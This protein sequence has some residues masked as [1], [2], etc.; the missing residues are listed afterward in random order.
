[1]KR[2]NAFLSVTISIIVLASALF[3]PNM[4]FAAGA[5]GTVITL[6]KDDFELVSGYNCSVDGNVVTSTA[7]QY[8]SFY[9]LLGKEYYIREIR[10]T[11]TAEGRNYSTSNNAISL[12]NGAATV[13]SLPWSYSVWTNGV[14]SVKTASVPEDKQQE[15]VNR[16]NFAGF[17]TAVPTVGG[18]SLT[19]EK[20]EIIE[21]DIL[22][23]QE[24]KIKNITSSEIGLTV[25]INEGD[26]IELRYSKSLIDKNNFEDAAEVG[27]SVNGTYN[28]SGLE[29]DTL[30]YLALRVCNDSKTGYFYTSATTL[31]ASQ[32][33]SVILNPDDFVVEP[34]S[35]AGVSG[36]TVQAATG[37]ESSFMLCLPTYY[38][39]EGVKITAEVNDNSFYT[40]DAGLQLFDGDTNIANLGYRTGFGKDSAQTRYFSVPENQRQTPVNTI[41]IFGKWYDFPT[42]D[43]DS[44]ITI[45]EIE[46][47]GSEALIAPEMEFINITG[48]TVDVNWEPID[49]AEFELWYSLEPLTSVNF[50]DVTEKNLAASGAVTSAVISGLTARAEYYFLLK[51]ALDGREAFSVGKVVPQPLDDDWIVLGEDDFKLISSYNCTVNGNVVTSTANQYPAFYISFNNGYHIQEIRITA[52]SEGRNYSTGDKAVSLRNDSETVYSLPWSWSVWSDGVQSVKTASVPEDKQQEIVNRINFGGFWRAAPSAGG[53][54]F[55]VNK[56]EIKGSRIIDEPSIV[57]DKVTDA[58]VT[59]NWELPDNIGVR[60]WISENEL[61][62]DNFETAEKTLV[63]SGRMRSAKVDG[64]KQGGLYYFALEVLNGTEKLLAFSS[65]KLDAAVYDFEKSTNVDDYKVKTRSDSDRFYFI[66]ASEGISASIEKTEEYSDYGNAFKMQFAEYDKTRW[67]ILYFY[68]PN[69]GDFAGDGFSVTV[70]KTKN[71]LGTDIPIALNVQLSVDGYGVYQTQEYWESETFSADTKR[72]TVEFYYEDFFL[73][74][75]SSQKMTKEL[76]EHITAIRFWFEIPTSKGAFSL[77]FDSVRVIN[78]FKVVREVEGLSFQN[79]VVTLSEG[80]STVQTPVFE[81][82]NAT[83]NDLTWSTDAP[84]VISVDEVSGNAVA[85]SLGIAT[86]YATAPSG[87]TASYK[88]VV[89]EDERGAVYRDLFSFDDGV[90]PDNISLGNAS[91]RLEYSRVDTGGSLYL[92]SEENISVVFTVNDY[93]FY[94]EGIGIWACGD[95]GGRYVS[96]DLITDDNEVFTYSLMIDREIGNYVTLSYTEF[97]SRNSGKSPDRDDII[98]FKKLRISYDGSLYVDS[99]KVKDPL[100]YNL[101]QF[102]ANFTGNTGAVITDNNNALG[103]F[104]YYFNLLENGTDYDWASSILSESDLISY[105]SD[106]LIYSL[107]FVDDGFV[108]QDLKKSVSV[109]LDIPQIFEGMNNIWILYLTEGK[110]QGVSA[111]I[112]GSKISFEAS[113]SGIYCMVAGSND[114]FLSRRIKSAEEVEVVID[115]G[116]EPQI[117]TRDITTI[118]RKKDSGSSASAPQH[119]NPVIFWIVIPIAVLVI[120]GGTVTGILLF[121]KHRNRGAG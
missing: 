76:S 20:I 51:A 112:V 2:L 120:A 93:E 33:N 53:A 74:S 67:P 27:P 116:T 28:I 101:R 88:I 54:Q 15:G 4:D 96:L 109:T 26:N 46:L 8:P 118:R 87:V 105:A 113:K 119:I 81:P 66:N 57:F 21:S 114:E 82:Y 36:N 13:Y 80:G 37:L 64:L 19:I 11:A 70:G 85:M 49:G 40:V 43:G 42:E 55:T 48:D 97:K 39:I 63:A 98:S 100:I 47:I 6:T 83:E 71:H 65:V 62:S 91:A 44:K 52:T 24:I 89:K 72:K 107:Y 5:E 104:K 58:S 25:E 38:Y 10:I 111:Y 7:N 106:A 90:I 94:G 86:V 75:D 31:P 3:I 18:A 68:A 115:A 99:I 108:Q 41:R 17:W 23:T 59:A 110:I 117:I 22:K 84:E 69:W 34:I 79:S 14:Q 45:Q 92:S 60:L 73:Q 95:G 61:T 121:R 16:I 56:I 103:D 1:M 9:I 32:G 30:Y 12:M 78:P 50:N 102:P 77:Y 29:A 35:N